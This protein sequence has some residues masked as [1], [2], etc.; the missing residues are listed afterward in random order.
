[1]NHPPK[2]D[3]YFWLFHAA[4][5][6][7]FILINFITRQFNHLESLEQGLVSLVVLLVVN[8][9]LCLILRWVLHRFDLLQS[10]TPGVWFRLMVLVVAMGFVSAVLCT[11][12]VGL[13]YLLF[14]HASTLV[15]F[16]LTVYQNWLVLTL[17][18]GIWTVLYLTINHLRQLSQLQSK[19]QQTQLRLKE[20]EL[21]HLTGQLNPH[22]LFNGLNNIRGLMLED[23]NRART[24]LTDLSEL[25]RYSLN[26]P[27]QPLTNLASELTV[28]QAYI[29]LCQI[30]YEDRLQYREQIDP[31]ALSC[32]VP[33][34]LI[35]LLVE[36]AIRHGID[37][38][39]DPGELYLGVRC[40]SQQLLI[41]VRNPGH[42]H[43]PPPS[44]N[45]LGLANIRK[46]LALL[47]GDQASLQVTT[48]L[49]Q[50]GIEVTL[51]ALSE[52]AT[53]SGVGS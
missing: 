4:V 43:E 48:Q 13:Y 15:F 18:L 44:G 42:W 22:F 20:A 40:Q 6:G 25:L 29:Q 50:V 26:T 19:Q 51:P 2:A 39:T 45:G 53:F 12:G 11:L 52:S 3:R 28:V 23:V 5:W 8:T 21:N 31:A 49:D 41:S 24:M 16:M 47:F 7:V 36:N 37:R 46:R 14:G 35:Q 34:M 33:P 10:L 27:K 1:M 9:A 17:M 30:Q 38:Q 32:Q